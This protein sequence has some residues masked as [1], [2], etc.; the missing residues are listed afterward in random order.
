MR[1]INS[2]QSAG[3]S[4]LPAILM[5]SIVSSVYRLIFQLLPHLVVSFSV[6]IPVLL[7]VSLR[8]LRGS[9]STDLRAS[10]QRDPEI[11]MHT[12]LRR[13]PPPLSSQSSQ[14]VPFSELFSRTLSVIL[15]AESKISIITLLTSDWV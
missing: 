1:F 2:P 10:V 5:T 3:R 12:G 4:K 7:A 11:Q 8:C 15:S 14:P 9:S 6:M 13:Q